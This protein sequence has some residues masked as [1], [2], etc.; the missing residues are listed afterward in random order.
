MRRL[1]LI[2]LSILSVACDSPRPTP[3]PEEA[4]PAVG[5][6]DGPTDLA[7]HIPERRCEYYS[8]CD[9]TLACAVEFLAENYPD[10]DCMRSCFELEFECLVD[11]DAEGLCAEEFYC[12]EDL[13]V[14]ECKAECG[15]E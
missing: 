7:V 3:A 2:T 6:F 8:T 5:E 10:N 1:A 11:Q 14:V 9:E 13:D 4:A 12:K 15:N